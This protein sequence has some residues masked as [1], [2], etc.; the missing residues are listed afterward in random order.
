MEKLDKI[1]EGKAKIIYSTSQ[2]DVL[3][4]KYKDSVTA[5]NGE[6]K[7]I[8]QGKSI[9]NNKITSIIFNKLSQNGVSNH[10]IKK[11]SD[12]EQLV[13]NVNIIPLEV[14]V[15]N[16]SAGSMS[17]RLGIAEG[18]LLKFPIVDFYY[19]NDDLGDPILTE[20]QIYVLNIATDEQVKQLSQLSLKIN[21][22]LKNIFNKINITLVDFKLEFGLDSNG[23][24][25]LADEISPDTC[26]LWDTTT[27]QILDKDI[28]RKNL[29]NI[30]L[31]Y[32]IVLERLE[33]L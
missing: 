28:Y 1:Y 23:E 4:V 30:I 18:T 7:D 20:S 24:I 10:F 33:K 8:I 15:R 27:K 26:R 31:G 19:K 21:D 3:W 25:L 11:L 29:G 12:T 9:L 6:K 14:V 32:E 16:I 2:K 22:V 13:K 5:F 17:K